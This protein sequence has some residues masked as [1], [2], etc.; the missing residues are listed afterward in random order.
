MIE[1][2]IL[3]NYEAKLELFSRFQ[4]HF[5]AVK[6]QAHITCAL[7]GMCTSTS[8]INVFLSVSHLLTTVI[9]IRVAFH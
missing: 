8:L 4:E 7:I 2:K 6:L 9:P 3:E 5:C 1:E